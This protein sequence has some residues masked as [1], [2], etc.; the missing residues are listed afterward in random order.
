MRRMRNPYCGKLPTSRRWCG[1]S[2]VGRRD[3]LSAIGCASAVLLA[4]WPVVGRAELVADPGRFLESLGVRAIDM[5][6]DDSLPMATREDQFR[7]LFKEGFDVPRIARFVLGRFARRATEQQQ[8]DFAAVFLEVIA[9]RFLPVFSGRTSDG[10]NIGR[11]LQDKSIAEMHLVQS[12][13]SLGGGQFSHVNWRVA[14]REDRYQI[15][16]VIV[17]GVSM[18][19]SLRS[20]YGSVLKH[21]SGDIDNL[22]ERLRDKL[23]RP[24]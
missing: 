15:L 10:F 20:E 21:N 24:D 9:Q 23:G 6:A 16:D 13:V 8:I 18:A 4:G 3:A 17:E 22:I 11:T 1:R 7:A 12:R 5:L 14:E 2:K 19:I